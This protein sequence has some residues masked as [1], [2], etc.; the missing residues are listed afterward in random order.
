MARKVLF[1]CTGNSCRSQMAEGWLRHYAADRAQVFSAGTSPVGLNP[2]AVAVMREVGISTSGQRS[3]H[4][5]ELANED[6]LFVITV[7]DSAR[8]QCPAF[9]GALYQLHWSFDDPARAGGFDEEKL[10]AFRR[11][12]DEIK[13]RVRTFALREGLVPGNFIRSWAANTAETCDLLYFSAA[14]RFCA[15]DAASVDGLSFCT[16]S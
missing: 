1:L 15:T 5:D 10:A 16:C 9:P 12:R 11:V 2:M 7:C 14:A 8:E 4:V 3:K 6:F 13:E